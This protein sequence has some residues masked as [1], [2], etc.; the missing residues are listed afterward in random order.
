MGAAKKQILI[1]D[2]EP[3][4]RALFSEAFQ[5]EGEYEVTTAQDGLEAYRLART[6]SFDTI[7]TDFRMPKLNG[8]KLITALRDNESNRTI[9]LFVI[10]AFKEEAATECLKANVMEGITFV[11]KPVSPQ[12]LVEKIKP[13]LKLIHGNKGAAKQV[14]K[15]EQQILRPFIEAVTLT[16]QT[17]G[18]AKEVNV[19]KATVMAPKQV[20]GVDI[21]TA[22]PIISAS[23]R[24][25]LYV[26]FPKDTFLKVV[27]NMLGRTETQITPDLEAAGVEFMNIIY[28]NT[29]RVLSE[30]GYEFQTGLPSIVRGADHIITGNGQYTVVGVPIASELGALHLLF[31]FS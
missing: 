7:C 25:T 31:C 11:E 4:N 12:Q 17:M 20:L 6:K 21:S 13:A 2:D 15:I 9:P 18:Q 16:I 29:K 3:I 5:D 27:S 10:T 1:V 19:G 8:A 30:Q 14:Q 26:S 22:V 28:G 23:F 24:G